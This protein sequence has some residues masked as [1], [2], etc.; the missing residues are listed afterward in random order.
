MFTQLLRISPDDAGSSSS[1]SS[2]NQKFDFDTQKRQLPAKL[3]SGVKP[4]LLISKL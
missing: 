1:P 4:I 3:T 2:E